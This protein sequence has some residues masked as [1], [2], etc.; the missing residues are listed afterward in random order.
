MLGRTERES[1]THARLAAKAGLWDS[2]QN[3]DEPSDLLDLGSLTAALATVSQI[4]DL[5]A[6]I[7]IGH[8]AAPAP[9]LERALLASN[10]NL[11]V[12]AA[13]AVTP[14]WE[15]VG[16]GGQSSGNVVV[17][18]AGMRDCR[19]MLRAMG[20]NPHL[21]PTRTPIS[22]R[23]EAAGATGSLLVERSLVPVGYAPIPGS[24]RLNVDAHLWYGLIE[25][26]TG[27]DAFAA[28]AQVWLAFGP[29]DDHRGSLQE[30]LG[31]I[32]HTGFDLKH[33]RSQQSL[34]GPHV[35][36]TSFTCQTSGHLDELIAEFTD[37]GVSHRVLA[38]LPGQ[39]FVPGPDAIA[40][41]W[42]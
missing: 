38:V 37:R 5:S 18:E 15:W 35:F 28:P 17:D 36:F 8:P 14:Q 6:I 22:E 30:S 34:A 40:P 42:A 23:V 25:D 39:E 20:A 26:V 4:D 24:E 13:V 31:V 16:P 21:V 12:T 7:H 1:G 9:D 11:M 27:W 41:R 10:A 33:L 29:R 32:A 3:R 19:H 2:E